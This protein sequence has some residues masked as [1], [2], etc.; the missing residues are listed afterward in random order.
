MLHTCVHMKNLSR[1]TDD[2]FG[3]IYSY[4]YVVPSSK[5]HGLISCLCMCTTYSNWNVICRY[6]RWNCLGSLHVQAYACICALNKETR[7]TY[8]SRSSLSLLIRFS[9]LTFHASYSSSSFSSSV[10]ITF[11]SSC[12]E[13]QRVNLVW[14][15]TIKFPVSHPRALPDKGADK[16]QCTN[17]Y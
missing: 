7:T 8:I 1:S 17:I 13:R 15:I 16:T 4:I 5:G 10:L 2:I 14:A 9:S 11:S 6:M 3:N 12:T